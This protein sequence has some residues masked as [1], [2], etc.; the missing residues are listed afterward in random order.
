MSVPHSSHVRGGPARQ[1]NVVVAVVELV[2][3]VAWA[4]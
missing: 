2:G 3:D 1:R 4:G